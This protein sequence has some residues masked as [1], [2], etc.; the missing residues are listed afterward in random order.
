[1]LLQ[2]AKCCFSGVFLTPRMLLYTHTTVYQV[3]CILVRHQKHAQPRNVCTKN[4]ATSQLVIVLCRHV[5]V[6]GRAHPLSDQ[7]QG[8]M[9]PA[10]LTA[11]YS[12]NTSSSSMQLTGME[13][14]LTLPAMKIAAAAVIAAVP[15]LQA[16]AAE[17][18]WRQVAAQQ[19]R[20]WP[21]ERT[22]WLQSLVLLLLLLVV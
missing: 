16:A 17:G 1:M 4:P 5:T 9:P 8:C 6:S 21:Q 13:T 14:L 15:A 22:L 12:T 20:V 2:P 3:G 10:R 11:S 19:A 7:H 18:A